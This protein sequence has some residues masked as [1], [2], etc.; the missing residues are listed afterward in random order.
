MATPPILNPPL[1]WTNQDLVLYHGTIDQFEASILARIRVSRGKQFRDFG[2]G[3]YTT[4]NLWQ[5]RS[6][7]WQTSQDYSGSI[8]RVIQLTLGRDALARLDT[9]WFVRCASDAEDYWSF[10][11]RCRSLGTHHGRALKRGWYDMVVGP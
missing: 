2:R 10:V 3:F 8:P 6:W 5:A 9:L 7:A 11:H 4:T 1:P